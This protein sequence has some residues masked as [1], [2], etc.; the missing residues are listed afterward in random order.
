VDDDDAEDFALGVGGGRDTI[1]G[2]LL[3][4][5]SLS[6]ENERATTGATEDSSPFTVN[7][8]LLQYYSSIVY[9]VIS[10]DIKGFGEYPGVE[11]IRQHISRSRENTIRDLYPI[12]RVSHISQSAWIEIYS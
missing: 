12:L 2:C 11:Y 8:L 5:W 10:V 9:V 1:K 3:I 7:T 4:F 6:I